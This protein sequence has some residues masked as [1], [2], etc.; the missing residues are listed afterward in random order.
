M[1]SG[2]ADL[3]EY[4]DGE[5]DPAKLPAF[6]THLVGCADCQRGLVDLM[7]LATL[8][9]EAAVRAAQAPARG[10]VLPFRRPPVVVMALAASLV[11]SVV[12]GAALW[13]TLS[14]GSEELWLG[15]SGSRLLEARV[16]R[17]EADRWRP[18]GVVRAEKSTVP[19]PSLTDLGALERRGDQLGIAVAYLIRRQPEQAA[20]YLDKLSPGAEAEVDRAAAALLRDDWLEALEHSDRALGAAPGNAQALWNR[21]LALKG[22]GLSLTA[23]AA[24]DQAADLGEPGWS[25]EARARA[26]S[27]RA[28]LQQRQK[29]WNGLQQACV[30]LMAQGTPLSGEEIRRA[31]GPA[32]EC[33]YEGVRQARTRER[34]QALRPMAETLDAL[35]GNRAAGEYV[36]RIAARDFSRRRPLAEAYAALLAGKMPPAEVDSFLDRLR[37]AG[38]TDLLLGALL[39]LPSLDEHMDEYVRLSAASQDAWFQVVAEEKQGDADR[40]QDRRPQAA[41]RMARALERCEPAWLSGPCLSLEMGLS[42]AY[43]AQ[44]QYV[45]ARDHQRKVL[46]RALREGDWPSERWALL[47]LG[48]IARLEMDLPQARAYL[49]E[50]MLRAQG[51]CDE[52]VWIKTNLAT[53][54]L[55][56]HQVVEA[57]R[58][59]DL[60]GTQCQAPADLSRLA[61]LADLSR[62]DPRPEDERVM[63]EGLAAARADPALSPGQRAEV[64]HLEGRF[65]IERDRVRGQALL[66]KAIAAAAALPAGE[67]H[68]EKAKAYSY[69]SLLMDAGKHGEWAQAIQLFA[70]ELGTPAPA[71]CALGVSVDDER[72]LVVTHGPG[73]QLVGHYDQGRTAPLTGIA[74]LVPERVREALRG[75][76]SVQVFARPPVAGLPDLLPAD[77][78]WSYRVSRGTPAPPAS[79]ARR[80][81]VTSTVPP[82]ALH[83]AP[84]NAPAPAGPDWAVL[85]GEAATPE[86]V[87]EAMKGATEIQIHAHGLVNPERSDAS[88]IALSPGARG[89]YALTA[90]D[91]EKVRLVGRP[92][93]LLA[94]CYSATTARD[95]HQNHG[96]A[97]A[98]VHAGAR[99][100]LAATREIPDADA[101]R[102]FD[103]VL[104]RIRGG[105]PAA[106][107]L[108]D[109]RVAWTAAGG[110]RWVEQVLLF[111]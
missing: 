92:V 95:L 81:L 59:L 100:V 50:E 53:A 78:A 111:E 56:N 24:F 58:H 36:E 102:F 54:Y 98:F 80:L 64:D 42:Y 9:E 86:R 104:E 108:R 60:G 79:P 8:G 20:P 68:A 1:T 94:A 17:A 22:M 31:P 77:V 13:R 52:I 39:H 35:A 106:V 37:A 69:T 18:Y 33:F 32:R 14:G 48:Q 19:T 67:T 16:S 71:V 41:E 23:A 91:L 44:H 75:C 110:G 5:L 105:Q 72:T 11:L 28:E 89:K 87:L 101:P 15:G 3:P 85:R 88:F 30:R 4:A 55:L 84:L 21:A 38:E 43:V 62:R 97:A 63:A 93:V 25:D 73:V 74:G 65:R 70:E 46:A 49:E 61:V 66:R 51:D 6:E 99:V 10:K 76:A 34:V 47:G 12:T 7:Q 27:L 103:G 40:E 57:R 82:A 26:A 29:A 96:L 109:A 107:A 45:P 90:G 2:C 83:L